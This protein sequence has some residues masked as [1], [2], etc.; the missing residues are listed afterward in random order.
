MKNTPAVQVTQTSKNEP[1]NVRRVQF[2]AC[3]VAESRYFDY[4]WQLIGASIWDASK[5]DLDNIRVYAILVIA[6]PDYSDSSLPDG[7]MAAG[8]DLVKFYRQLVHNGLERR[9]GYEFANSVALDVKGEIR[10][11]VSWVYYA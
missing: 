6:A 11:D 9:Y 7:T 10:K 4:G 5:D 1:E 8:R 2:V 3:D